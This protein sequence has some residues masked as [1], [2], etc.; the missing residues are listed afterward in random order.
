MNSRNAHDFL[1]SLEHIRFVV[2][3]YLA[4]AGFGLGNFT[5]VLDLGSG[6]GRFLFAFQQEFGP[7]QKVYGCEV[8]KE[9]AEWCQQ[10]IDFAEVLHTA[11][12]PPLP[13]ADS[14]FDLVY[15]LSV[16]THLRLDLQF[17]WAWEIHRILKPGG[18][19]FLTFH[20][21][22]FIPRLFQP[23]LQHPAKHELYSVGDSGLFFYSSV[24]GESGD[25]GQVN[26]AA[27]QNDRFVRQQF[28][29]F[30]VAKAFPKS[31]L[32]GEQDLYIFQ[33]PVNSPSMAI[34]TR[35]VTVSSDRLQMP[36]SLTGQTR[37]RV[38]PRILEAVVRPLDCLLEMSM[39]FGRRV[40]INQKRLLGPC[41]YFAVEIEIPK[42]CGEMELSLAC[43]TRQDSI[44]QPVEWN[45]LHLY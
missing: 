28:S 21:Q 31:D 14:Q 39:G 13:Y 40:P 33:R 18:V 20:G 45:F 3:R 19:A 1:N 43:V 11:I 7:N 27:A 12:E 25:E 44:P 4:D 42:Y 23:Y 29:A 30:D 8:H 9:C 36:L 17:K 26:V 2:P 34:P 37:L 5:S 6:V 22:D 35:A 16:F 41:Q 10:N 38:Y 15:G 32:A 24:S